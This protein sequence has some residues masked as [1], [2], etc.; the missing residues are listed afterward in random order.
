MSDDDRGPVPDAKPPCIVAV[1]ALLA[2]AAGLVAVLLGAGFWLWLQGLVVPAL[3]AALLV[4]YTVSVPVLRRGGAGRR[5]AAVGSR[6]P[7]AATFR[8]AAV[9]HNGYPGPRGHHRRL[10]LGAPPVPV[11]TSAVLV[12]TAGGAPSPGGAR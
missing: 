1:L 10:C 9:V 4:L 7:A 5:S 6:G 3:L 2:V 8:P 12:A 11:H